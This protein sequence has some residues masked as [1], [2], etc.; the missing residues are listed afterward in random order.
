MTDTRS[1]PPGSSPFLVT[2]GRCLFFLPCFYLSACLTLPAPDADAP[3]PPSG[4][5]VVAAPTPPPTARPKPAPPTAPHRGTQ[6]PYTVQGKTY[7]PQADS[8]G[9]A[10]VG[11]ASWYGKAFHGRRTAN[12]E[13]F[14]MNALTAAHKTLPLPSYV[15]VRNLTNQRTAVVKVNDRGPF[16]G[17]RL[18]D[19]SYAAAL[20][21]GLQFQGLGEVEVVAI[22]PPVETGETP[23]PALEPGVE[24]ALPDR[25]TVQ[26][27]RYL[28]PDA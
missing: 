13:P 22:P 12:G 6:R 27:P 25:R 7:H 24:E 19:L 1:Q 9:Y 3:P 10:A 18:I 5:V 21:L 15:L 17:D 11:T 14:D 20:R 28:A 26:A 2:V 23:P 4:P 8:R 16:V